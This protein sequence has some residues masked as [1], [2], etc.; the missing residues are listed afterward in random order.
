MKQFLAHHRPWIAVVLAGAA[1]L[2][3]G[4]GLD[5]WRDAQRARA[6]QQ[7]ITATIETADVI[8]Q[9]RPP[10]EARGLDGTMRELSQFDGHVI[11]L[12]F[13]ATWCPPCLEEIPALMALQRE[14]GPRGLQVVGLALDE[15][16]ATRAFVVEHGVDYPVLVGG[17]SGFAL[18]ERFGN[19]P[20]SLPYT[21]V[22]DRTGVIRAV[23]RGAL[24]RDEAAGLVQP[25]L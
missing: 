2:G 13:W 9:P 20:A 6:A 10:V 22:V 7:A 1:G 19:I 23:H 5:H 25:L 17:D 24:S 8:G 18:A 14:L 11:L 12:N 3:A 16:E 15:F 21:V 4:I